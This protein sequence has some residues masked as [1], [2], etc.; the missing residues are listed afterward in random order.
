MMAG[1]MILRRWLSKPELI[2]YDK[3]QIYSIVSL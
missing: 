1:Y 3:V 2:K